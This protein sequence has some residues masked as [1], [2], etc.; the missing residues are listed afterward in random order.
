MAI[1]RLHVT[2]PRR[3]PID[4]VYVA[5]PATDRQDQSQHPMKEQEGSD[6]QQDEQ[7]TQDAGQPED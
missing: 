3:R 6:E 7:K 2:R 4:P 5:P 1:H